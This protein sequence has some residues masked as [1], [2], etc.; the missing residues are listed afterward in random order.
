MYDAL[1]SV[2]MAECKQP[3]K[4]DSDRNENGRSQ[5]VD[6]HRRCIVVGVVFI[7]F[8]F[9]LSAE[10]TADSARS[11]P[12]ELFVA[13]RLDRIHSRCSQRRVDSEYDPDRDGN[14]EG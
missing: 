1:E 10:K 9:A 12:G 2:F 8:V 13:E 3:T 7:T 4:D 6:I 5:Q 14:P 11:P